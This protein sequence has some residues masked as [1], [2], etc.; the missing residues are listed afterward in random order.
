MKKSILLLFFVIETALPA[1]DFLLN[2]VTVSG[3]APN[4]LDYLDKNP[5]ILRL[6][7]G[8]ALAVQL[9]PALLEHPGTAVKMA[10]A[11]PEGHFGSAVAE[12]S[13]RPVNHS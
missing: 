10:G 9:Q 13:T 6:E 8:T 11:N 1:A 3:A 5:S 7:N 2:P 12:A 4:L